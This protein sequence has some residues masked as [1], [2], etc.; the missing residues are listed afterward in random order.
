M[1]LIIVRHGQTIEN[2]KKICQGQSL[3]TLSEKGIKQ[4]KKI[5][6][7]LKNEKIDK[8]YVS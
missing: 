2:A 4:A 6:E 3:G 5:G 1:K 8:I 7:R